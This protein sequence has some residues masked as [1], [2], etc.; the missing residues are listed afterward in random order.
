MVKHVRPD[1]VGI[2]LAVVP[3]VR[4]KATACK[5]VSEVARAVEMPLAGI[6]RPPPIVPADGS[7]EGD[8][9]LRRHVVTPG[10]VNL[11]M[12]PGKEG[13][14]CRRAEWAR[15]VR[16]IEANTGRREPV[17]VWCIDGWI[18]IR[19]DHRLGLCV[20]HNHDN[21]HTSPHAALSCH[22]LLA[23]HIVARSSEA[24]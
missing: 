7:H 11:R 6:G 23:S 13:A 5:P 9:S 24:G 16:A 22:P 8:V 17:K 4:L 18:A 1:V 3:P 20:G 10:A 15:S 19:A 21:V 14:A 2:A 12:H